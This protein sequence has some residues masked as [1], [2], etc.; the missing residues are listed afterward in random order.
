[1]TKKSSS[2]LASLRRPA[3]IIAGYSLLWIALD[4]ATENLSGK[5]DVSLWYAPAGLSFA[6]LLVCGL[7][8]AP[9]VVL[10]MLV[11]LLLFRG[12]MDYPIWLLFALPVI[13]TVVWVWPA[14]LLVRVIKIDPCLSRMRDVLYFVVVGCVVAPFIASVA[15]VAG[16][17]VGG[18]VPWSSFVISTLGGW[19]GEATGAGM[20]TTLVLIAL[21]PYP[22]MWTSSLRASA[23]EEQ[24]PWQPLEGFT[25]PKRREIPEVL[26]Q[27]VL[28]AATMFAAYGTER[29]VRL[30]FAYLVF[31]PLIWVAIRNDLARTAVCILIINV[32]ALL[33]VG[34]VVENTNPI[35]IQFGLMTMTLV[36]ILLGGL[37]TERRETSERLIRDASHDRL[38]GLPDRAQFSNVLSDALD[39]SGE[40]IMVLA[41]DLDRFASVNNALGHRTGDGLLAAVAERLSA[42]TEA[43][44]DSTTARAARIG[45]DAFAVLIEGVDS[46]DLAGRVAGSLLE[47]LAL[48]YEVNGREVYAT[49]SAGVVVIYEA[50]EEAED[51][52][53]DADTALQAAK[54]K[55]RARYAIF[56][57]TMGEAAR[58]R[59]EL[60]ADLRRAIEREEFILHY[61]P[62]FH[63]GTS[64]I[65]GAEALV[66]WEHPKRG[67][68]QPAEFI[69]LA[70]QSGLIVPIGEWVL[71]EACRWAK[72]RQERDPSQPPFIVSVNLSAK[73]LERP[74]F[75]EDLDA[76]LEDTELDPRALVLEITENVLVDGSGSIRDLLA[77]LRN[78]SVRLAVDDFGTGYSSLSYLSRFPV[79]IIKIDSSFISRMLP[80]NG[81]RVSS[82]DEKL[83]SGIIDLAHDQDLSV[84]AEGVENNHQLNLLTGMNCDNIQGYFISKPLAGDAISELVESKTL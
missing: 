22:A 83:V 9:A 39:R 33:L 10:T 14:A 50:P 21:R 55:G 66:R 45:G 15:G 41:V 61:Q 79:D 20:V 62:V 26:G 72:R 58:A 4:V 6:L 82:A 44:E 73:Q 38:T 65:V 42:F 23:R 64:K 11:H 68:L 75:L 56:D 8:Y 47:E 36:G 19:A 3:L 49:A 12:G 31:L 81:D 67:L 54:T 5:L 32:G 24:R 37:V 30:D 18:D 28:L 70:E 51:L 59:L 40:G 2:I 78:R 1:M 84:V 77:S 35:L 48:P 57:K 76:V 53:R 71:R 7:R 69:A 63:L 13:Q 80:E 43:R 34:G 16:Y 60:D 74:S 52:L 46:E 27:A 17:A 29:G 25:L